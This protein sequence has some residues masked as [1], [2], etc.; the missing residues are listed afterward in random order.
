[1]W[2]TTSTTTTTTTTT[3]TSATALEALPE[4]KIFV[5]L[6]C[7][8]AKKAWERY[9]LLQERF[10][11]DYNM[12]MHL[13]SLVF[14]PQAFVG[15]QAAYLIEQQ[16]KNKDKKQAFVDACFQ[17]QD[18]FKR[19][20]LGED[21]S[22]RQVDAIF[23]DIA[24]QAGV[25]DQDKFTREYFLLHLHD[26][27]QVIKPSYGEVKVALNYGVFGTPKHVINEKLVMDTESTWGPEE[28]EQKLNE[29]RTT[30]D[31]N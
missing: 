19:D 20:A 8:F 27:E 22:K 3:T 21:Y 13:T 29:L 31:H 26:W 30:S 16:T 18:R 2:S 25:F 23:A 15:Q 14:H 6:Q 7:P 5:D 17:N 9:P 12:T 1:M 28:W 24:Q 4:W 10:G 11:N